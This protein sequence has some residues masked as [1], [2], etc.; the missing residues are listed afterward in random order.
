MLTLFTVPQPFRGEF[1]VI[2]RNAIRSWAKLDP[3]CELIL[4]GD[5][6]GT[7]DFVCGQAS[8]QAER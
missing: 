3:A 6:E 5:E 1:S 7:R 2:Q 4:L 8:E